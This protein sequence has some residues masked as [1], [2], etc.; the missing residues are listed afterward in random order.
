[1]SGEAPG[2]D[3]GGTLGN[4]LG[5]GPKPKILE[6]QVTKKLKENHD[7]AFTSGAEK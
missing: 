6:N 2:R 5:N 3:L 4:P 7:L 1:M